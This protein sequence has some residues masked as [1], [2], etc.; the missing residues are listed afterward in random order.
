MRTQ[1]RKEQR[2]E[3]SI[4][5]CGYAM[6]DTVRFWSIHRLWVTEGTGHAKIWL[7]S[8]VTERS[9]RKVWMWY[10]TICCIF[11]LLYSLISNFHPGGLLLLTLLWILM[12]W[13]KTLPH[14][15]K[16]C[17][18][19]GP[20]GKVTKPKFHQACHGHRGVSIWSKPYSNMFPG[21]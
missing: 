3:E 21:R 1:E 20:P 15:M 19:H 12:E 16:F 13:L 4:M 18:C 7:L 14:L 2:D 11:W 8:Q 10:L 17:A 5:L 9:W 6:A